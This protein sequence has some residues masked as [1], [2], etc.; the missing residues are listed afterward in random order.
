MRNIPASPPFNPVR[1]FRQIRSVSVA[2]ALKLKRIST[3]SFSWLVSKWRIIV[4]SLQISRLRLSWALIYCELIWWRCLL[5]THFSF[6]W[7]LEFSKCVSTSKLSCRA[8][9]GVQTF[10]MYWIFMYYVFH[11]SGILASC[12]YCHIFEYTHVL[13]CILK[14]WFNFINVIHKILLIVVA[15]K[16]INYSLKRI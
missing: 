9:Y 15:L 8:N 11:V 6:D 2:S 10:A 7:T 16:S 1:I 14:Y 13:A 12:M 5:L 4:L 3:C